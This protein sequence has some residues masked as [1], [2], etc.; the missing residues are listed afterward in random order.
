MAGEADGTR[1][2]AAWWSMMH[3]SIL[4]GSPQ[5]GGSRVSSFT[6]VICC[7]ASIVSDL[8]QC[9]LV[10]CPVL[11]SRAVG[12]R[13][14][15]AAILHQPGVEAANKT[16]SAFDSSL[17]HKVSYL[18]LLDKQP[19]RSRSTGSRSRFGHSDGLTRIGSAASRRSQGSD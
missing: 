15:D 18:L 11:L 14:E 13:L 12:N 3:V 17:G 10:Q 9:R 1:T 8:V 5:F 19:V 7:C 6:T 2:A 4:W 16:C